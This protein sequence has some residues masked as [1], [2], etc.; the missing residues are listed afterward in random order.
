MAVQAS[1][2]HP[3]GPTGP[4][5]DSLDLQDLRD[6]RDPPGMM[7]LLDILV[8]LEITENR[9]HQDQWD[10]KGN[11]ELMVPMVRM[12]VLV[13]MVNPEHAIVHQKN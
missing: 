6:L 12:V 10:P 8:P 1:L 5:E 2:R 3:T 11:P 4:L 13:R 9:D 7:V